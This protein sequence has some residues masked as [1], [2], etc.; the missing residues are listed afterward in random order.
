MQE[1]Q[2][3]ESGAPASG[4]KPQQN[5]KPK[6]ELTPQQIQQRKKMIIFPLMF[7]AFAGS[8]YLIFAPSGDKQTP[9]EAVGGFNADIPQPAGDGIIADKQKAYE[10]EQMNRKQQDKIKS[11]QDFGFTLGD[12]EAGQQSVDLLSE[13][14][15]PQPSR[16][17]GSSYRGGSSSID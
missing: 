7:L 9:T 17:G 8:M 5:E 13:T 2:K 6:R 10:E 16:G 15:D 12:D 4:G 11:L 3:N 1:V 14:E